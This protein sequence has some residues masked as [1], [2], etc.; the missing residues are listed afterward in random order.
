MFKNKFPI[1]KKGNII[2]KLD[3]D[4]L[5]D[6]SLGFLKTEYSEYCD[7]ILTGFDLSI[8]EP[9][10]LVRITKGIVLYNSDFYVMNKE[11][12]V[13][14]PE[15]EDKYIIKVRLHKN[16]EGRRYFIKKG[17]IVLEN[18]FEVSKNEIELGRF[19]TRVGANLRNNY[20]NFSDLKIDFNVID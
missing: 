9:K 10:K 18:G 6:N 14:I 12:V 17:D 4:L 13:K 7:G 5:R 3:L 1:F 20:R 2:S 8:D 15:N 19:I 16:F 11:F